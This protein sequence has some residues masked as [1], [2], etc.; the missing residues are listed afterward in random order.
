MLGVL[1]LL[2][3]VV[4]LARGSRQDDK[5]L[6]IYFDEQTTLTREQ[7]TDFVLETLASLGDVE[8]T[9][10]KYLGSQ[11]SHDRITLSLRY[12]KDIAQVAL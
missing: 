10:L 3:T 5:D 9:D 2:C 7:Q 8:K 4:C 6:T 11:K 12:R 1:T